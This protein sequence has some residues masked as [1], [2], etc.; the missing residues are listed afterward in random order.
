LLYI[1]DIVQ[2]K[3]KKIK[4]LRK[5]VVRNLKLAVIPHKDNGYRPHLIRHYGLAAIVVVF[6]GL[7][8]VYFI[9]NSSILGKVLGS[10]TNITVS[11]LLKETN[12]ERAKV[13]LSSLVLND[14]LNQAANLKA[15]DMFINQY[16]SH[17]SPSGVTPWKWF[18]DVDYDYTEA[19]ENLAKDFSSARGT[20]SAWMDSPEHRANI[21]KAD[22]RDVGFAV[23]SGELNSKSTLLVV[24][25]YGSLASSSTVFAT[26]SFTSADSSGVSNI[27]TQFAMAFNSMSPATIAGLILIICAIVVALLAHHYRY[28]LPKTL[29]KSW[30]RHHGAYKAAG[31]ALVALI[32]IFLTSSGQI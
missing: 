16:W 23:V 32:F 5:S 11:E 9:Y 30:R 3:L 2:K 22:Y 25:M 1:N 14:K 10:E 20:I 13:G 19:G 7:Q 17:I 28:K 4:P 31:L 24:A 21:L 18:G 26:K 8:F 6:I 29:Q 27:F 15:D 12:E